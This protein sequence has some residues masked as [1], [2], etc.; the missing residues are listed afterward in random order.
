MSTG[1]MKLDPEELEE[2]EEIWIMLVKVGFAVFA[3]LYPFLLIYIINIILGV[4]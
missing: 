2:L 4:A 3:F 1:G